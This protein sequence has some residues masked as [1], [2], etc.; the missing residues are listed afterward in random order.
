MSY[1]EGQM[2]GF[3][4]TRIIAVSTSCLGDWPAGSLHALDGSGAVQSGEHSLRYILRYNVAF[5]TCS[6]VLLNLINATSV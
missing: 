4:F 2:T 6:D 3:G 1:G 5:A